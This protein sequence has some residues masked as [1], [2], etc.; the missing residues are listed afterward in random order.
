MYQLPPLEKMLLYF[1]HSLWLNKIHHVFTAL[2]KN[3]HVFDFIDQ[4]NQLFT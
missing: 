4:V 1:L 2:D 3:L